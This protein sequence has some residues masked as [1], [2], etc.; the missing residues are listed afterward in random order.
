MK[1]LHKIAFLFLISGLLITSSCKKSF[2]TDVNVNPNVLTT[3]SPNLLLPTVEAALAYTQGGDISRYSALLMQQMYGANSQSQQYYQYNFN[4]GNFDN[5]WP[6]LY[7]STL[8]NNYTLIKI[9]DAGGYNGYSGISRIIMAYAL[10]VSVDLW[11]DLPY[12]QAF[13]GN[14]SGGSLHPTYDKAAALYDSASKLIDAGIVF[15]SAA[16]QG[17]ITPSTD[18]VIYGGDAAKWIKFGHAIKARLALH[19]SKGSTTMASTA[20]S[21]IAQSF[22]SNAESAQYIFGTQETSANTWYQFYRDRPGDENFK[23]SSLAIQLKAS[24]DPRYPFYN[25][26]STDSKGNRTSYFNVINAPVEFITYDELLFMSAEATLRV[27]G[28]LAAAQTLFQAAITADLTKLGVPQATIT[29]YVAAN[30]TLTGTADAAIAKVAAQEYI[31]LF[32]NPETWV[33]WRRTGSP[34]LTTTSPG[35]EIPRRLLYPQTEINF[36]GANVPANVTLY[37]PKIFWDN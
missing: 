37:S 8:E 11:G 35:S 7:T 25:M 12:S 27:S 17:T 24:G 18:D 19:Q 23:S 36:N 4:P 9:S 1:L 30:G 15:L 3:V 13:Q 16:N 14:V 10:Q 26:D 29:A 20:L 31:A 22:T 28:D 34:A 32:L 5:L 2:F 33:L 6:D 21:E